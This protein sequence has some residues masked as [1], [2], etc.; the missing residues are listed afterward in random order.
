[1][2]QL[3]LFLLLTPTLWAQSIPPPTLY[4][5]PEAALQLYRSTLLRLRQEYT[6][7]RDLPDLKFFLFGMGDRTKYIYRNGRLINALTGNI[8]EQWVVKNEI[9]VPS[10]YLVHLTLD[11]GVTIQIREDETGVW[12]LQT[13]PAKARNVAKMPK[14]RR[15]GATR[16]VLNLPRFADH[17]FGLV[18]RVLH[19]E[20]LI[21]VVTGTDGIGRPVPNLLVYQ[22]P[23]YRDAAL[24]AMVMRETGNL[25]LIRDWIMTIRDPFDRNNAGIAEADNPGQVLFLVSL[26]ADQNHPVVQSALDSLK[27]FKREN[28]IIGKTDGAEHPVFQTKWLKYGLKSLGLPDTYV[29]PNQYDSYSSLFW[30]D[31]TAEHVA[32]K[33]FGEESSMNYPYLTWAEDH[34]YSRT[35]KPEKRGMLGTIDYPL[36]WEQKASQAHYP[37][38]TVLDKGFVKQKLAFPH[39]WHAAEMFLQLFDK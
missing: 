21:N 7:H 15:V 9:I 29:I 31:Y 38:L 14:P 30:W 37:G 33:K 39:S 25:R 16:S 5:N 10:E 20:I 19:H 8:E 1:M 22:K 18:L 11:E 27:Q 17:T 13:P 23:W 36:S 35:E 2:K 28:Y 12:I 26:V 32:G 34:F 6:N 24:M 4:P 3:F